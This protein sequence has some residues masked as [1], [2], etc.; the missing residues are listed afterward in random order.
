MSVGNH[1]EHQ[2]IKCRVNIAN[3]GRTP[4]TVS[5]AGIAFLRR[6]RPA[7]FRKF[8]PEV[9]ALPTRLGPLDHVEFYVPITWLYQMRDEHPEDIMVTYTSIAGLDPEFY[10][11][12]PI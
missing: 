1:P 9:L 11:P 3:I 10:P 6:R 2:D 8:D 7:V 4:A 5:A 12:L